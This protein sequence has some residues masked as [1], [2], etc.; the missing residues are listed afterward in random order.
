MVSILSARKNRKWSEKLVS[1]LARELPPEIKVGRI[2][3]QFSR[4]VLI[5]EL[6]SNSPFLPD[7]SGIRALDAGRGIGIIS[8]IL[9]KAGF[10]VVSLD[11]HPLNPRL[12]SLFG[13]YQIQSV[14]HPV[15]GCERIL[16]EGTFDLV[17]FLDVIEHLRGSPKKALSSLHAVMSP[18]GRFIISTPNFAHLRNRIWMLMGKSTYGQQLADFYEMGEEFEGHFR[19]YTVQ[20]L[21]KVLEWSG[22]RP[23]RIIL[24]NRPLLP[25]REKGTAYQI[26]QLPPSIR[27]VPLFAYVY[28]SSL[29][30]RLRSTIFAIGEKGELVKSVAI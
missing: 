30:R 4:Y 17:L 15:E 11:T 19:E 10:R 27:H 8:L 3:G 28:L 9:A 1:D 25:A 2:P 24:S 14:Q 21:R 16:E 12:R 18:R 23:T 22:L 29:A 26:C 20:E 13:K 6:I 7:L 5:L